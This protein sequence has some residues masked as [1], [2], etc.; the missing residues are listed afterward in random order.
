MSLK[1]EDP[2][3]TI[4]GRKTKSSSK[5]KR[6]HNSFFK[7][8]SNLAGQTLWISSNY[9]GLQKLDIKIKIL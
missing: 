2:A 9:L 6:K 5:I 3:N 8:N 1:D 4:Q 7:N